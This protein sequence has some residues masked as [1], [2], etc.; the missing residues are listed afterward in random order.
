MKKSALTGASVTSAFGVQP[1][2]ERETRKADD[3][4]HRRLNF[5]DVVS[6]HSLRARMRSDS[7]SCAASCRR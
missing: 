6:A 2:R 1:G 3:L 4:L 5:A 7:D